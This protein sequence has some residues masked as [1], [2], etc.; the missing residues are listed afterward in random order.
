MGILYLIGTPIGN[1]EDI[2]LRAIKTIGSVD[3]LLCE[4]TRRTGILIQKLDLKFKNSE[5][6][7]LDYEFKKPKLIS[8]QEFNEGK[9]IPEVISYLKQGLNVGLVSD[10][11]MPSISDPGFKL[12][13]EAIKEEIKIE[14]IPGP[15][16]ILT[17]LISSGLPTDKFVF[18][19][20]LSKK[21]EKRRKVLFSLRELSFKDPKNFFIKT[22]IFF[23]S[24]FRLLSFLFDVKEIF[25]DIE[26][27]V[28]KELTKVYEEIYRGKISSATVH[29]SKS[30][31]KG[32]FTICLSLN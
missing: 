4:D 20:Y 31:P 18:L 32:E 5:I 15:S 7:F 19:G 3:C 6:R 29:F 21:K 22:Y 11:G 1:M 28:C 9:R 25:G 16:A 27:A 10:A 8:Y 17:A 14:T 26:V 23:E 30:I 2:T 12:I 24:P 13:R